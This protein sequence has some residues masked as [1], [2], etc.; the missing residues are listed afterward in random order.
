MRIF[1]PAGVKF[2]FKCTYLCLLLQGAQH[3]SIQRRGHAV[4][5]SWFENNYLIDQI[6]KYLIICSIILSTGLNN[7]LLVSHEL[8]VP[9]GDKFCE[10]H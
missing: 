2:L 6:I 7:E 1:N 9:H 5:R 8:D 4:A 3:V 10:F